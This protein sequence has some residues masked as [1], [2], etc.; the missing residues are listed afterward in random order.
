MSLPLSL[1]FFTP[2][3]AHLEGLLE[4]VVTRMYGWASPTERMPPPTPE[5]NPSI[6]QAASGSSS[7][8]GTN[9]GVAADGRARP[10]VTHWMT[11]MSTLRSNGT[12]EPVACTNYERCGQQY[13]S[14]ASEVG[15]PIVG[16]LRATS[17]VPMMWP[18]FN[19]NGRDY[20]GITLSFSTAFF[21]Q[22]P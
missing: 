7:I 9:S 13:S 19:R 2:A 11:L 5:P 6:L 16:C 8:G 1:P 15:W 18:P 4:A 17:A 14:L 12:F 3:A 22:P 10:V 20:Y 21:S